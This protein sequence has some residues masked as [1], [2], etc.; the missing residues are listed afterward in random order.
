M[1]DELVLVT[2]ENAITATAEGL[3]R[4]GGGVSFAQVPLSI[5]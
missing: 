1:R 4:L 5:L 2:N 3:L